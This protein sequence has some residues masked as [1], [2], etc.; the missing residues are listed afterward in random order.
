[1]AKA[2]NPPFGKNQQPDL[3]IHGRW[4]FSDR[5]PPAIREEA[6]RKK[7]KRGGKASGKARRDEAEQTWQPHALDV[8]IEIQ[9][10]D[11]SIIQISL[12]E[13]IK[14]R[15]RLK[16][17]CPKSQLVKAISRWQQEGKLAPRKKL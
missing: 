13:K 15:W 5:D 1:M 7:G 11:P 14:S 6:L 17:H 16:I 3:N 12:A 2:D 8:A 9:A 4:R 10:E